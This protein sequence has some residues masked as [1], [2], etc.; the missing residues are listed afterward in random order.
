[1]GADICERH[2]VLECKAE[3]GL[4]GAKIDLSFPSVGATENII[5]AAVLAE[6]TTTIINAA[7]EPEI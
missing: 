5:L 7:R 6:G 2:G 3:N 4:K 1:M